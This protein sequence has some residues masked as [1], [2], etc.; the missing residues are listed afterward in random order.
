MFHSFF[1]DE[2]KWYSATNIA[3]S[4]CIIELLNQCN[5]IPNTLSRI[6]GNTD[7]FSDHYRC[8]TALYMLSI[9][10]QELS[11]IIDLDIIAPGHGIELVYS[12]SAIYKSFLLQL[13]TTI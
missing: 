2:I 8:A 7:S 1:S 10:S 3:H 6:W 4:K 12:I 9:L 11:V 5:I 13:I